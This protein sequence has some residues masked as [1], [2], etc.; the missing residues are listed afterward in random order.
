MKSE[1]IWELGGDI[2]LLS[3]EGFIFNLLPIYTN[4][5]FTYLNLMLKLNHVHYFSINHNQSLEFSSNSC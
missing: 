2:H 5:D 3:V 4:Y 1:P